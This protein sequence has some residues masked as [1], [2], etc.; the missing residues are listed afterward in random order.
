[1]PVGMFSGLKL[2][3]VTDGPDQVPFTVLCTTLMRLYTGSRVEHRVLT[4]LIRAAELYLETEIV[5]LLLTTQVPT[6]AE[7][8]TVFV[9]ATLVA[10]DGVKIPPGDT[11]GLPLHVPPP[12]VAV[13]ATGVVVLHKG[14][15]RFNA[16]VTGLLITRAMVW[17]NGQLSCKGLTVTV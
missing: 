14:P 9:P 16:G 17:V 5:P 6:L 15:G 1:M 12:G 2:L 7:Y 8:T 13:K 11:P 4:V 10:S 3:L